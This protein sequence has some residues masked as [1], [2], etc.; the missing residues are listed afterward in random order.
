MA[1]EGMTYADTMGFPLISFLG[2]L[3]LLSLFAT[4]ATGSLFRK[5]YTGI[6]VVWHYRLGG[7]TAFLGLIYGILSIAAYL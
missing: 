1:L 6:P 3:T 5:G 2:A 4:A 7:L